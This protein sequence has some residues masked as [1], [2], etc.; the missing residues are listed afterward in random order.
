MPVASRL[1][2]RPYVAA[3][4]GRVTNRPFCLVRGHIVR[5]RPVHSDRGCSHM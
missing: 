1:M 5:V 3:Q 2:N 4:N